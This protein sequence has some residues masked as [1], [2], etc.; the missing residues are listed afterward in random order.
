MSLNQPT[1]FTI[2]T[3][4][5]APAI[6]GPTEK[7]TSGQFLH[8][9]N[10]FLTSNNR[11]Y[12]LR[13]QAVEVKGR[14]GELFN[15]ASFVVDDVQENTKKHYFLTE[16]SL[17]KAGFRLTMTDSGD[18]EVSGSDKSVVWSSGTG[19]PKHHRPRELDKGEWNGDSR[20]MEQEP[21]YESYEM[22]LQDDGNAVINGIVDR[23]KTDPYYREERQRINE[24][25]QR[26]H[27]DFVGGGRY[28]DSETYKR[29]GKQE[30]ERTQRLQGE[31]A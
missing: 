26:F 21:Q 28:M 31:V 7:L 3:E 6:N 25:Y 27:D 29:I 2:L 30:E 20:S 22:V 9:E 12:L 11:R 1:S 23:A 19:R 8:P 17:N 10:Q 18:L 13:V 5:Q 4:S 16:L 15:E 24:R 14:A